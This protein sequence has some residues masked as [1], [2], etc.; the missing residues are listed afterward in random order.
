[1][2]LKISG[3]WIPLSPQKKYHSLQ[4]MISSDESDTQQLIWP[5]VE[6]LC[7][8]FSIYR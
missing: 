2:I 7:P 1:M 4:V 6:R 5:K 3:A 8:F